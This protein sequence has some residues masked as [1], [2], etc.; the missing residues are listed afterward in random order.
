MNSIGEF[1]KVVSAPLPPELIKT[2]SGGRGAELR[3]ISGAAVVDLV[4]QASA[5]FK[6]WEIVKHWVEPCAPTNQC[7]KDSQPPV[8]HVHGRL[9]VIVKDEQGDNM[10][11]SSDGFGAQP[12]RGGQAEQ[13]HIF[14]SAARD[15]FKVAASYFGIGLELYR[16]EMDQA[17]FDAVN[18]EN[19]WTAEEVERFSKELDYIAEMKQLH[20]WSD[21]ELDQIVAEFSSNA[22]TSFAEI[23]PGNICSFVEWMRQALA[24]LNSSET[25]KA[26]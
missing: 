22:M 1:R 2:R 11:L 26:S 7:A 13:E 23:V 8:A 16:D 14:K 6:K 21:T 12:I 17:V 20:G 25:E 19:P 15:A 18:A 24:A 5:Y 9:T 4:N 10:E 3:Y